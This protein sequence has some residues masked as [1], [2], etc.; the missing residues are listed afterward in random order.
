[1]NVTIIYPEPHNIVYTID[2]SNDWGIV[3]KAKALI[4]AEQTKTEVT[5]KALPIRYGRIG[6]PEIKVKL[7]GRE[8]IDGFK[9][10]LEGLISGNEQIIL[11]VPKN[12]INA[13]PH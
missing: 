1:M 12:I 7:V 5:V 4:N 9:E 6:I 2:G 3:G 11:V 10:E 13:V 8:E